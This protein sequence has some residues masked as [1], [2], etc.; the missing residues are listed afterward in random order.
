MTFFGSEHPGFIRILPF[1][2]LN[3]PMS[4]NVLAFYSDQPIAVCLDFPGFSNKSPSS[5]PGKSGRLVT[6]LTKTLHIYTHA[7]HVIYLVNP[8]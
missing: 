1:S 5:V 6:Q 8:Y 2:Q 3:L 7:H 4:N